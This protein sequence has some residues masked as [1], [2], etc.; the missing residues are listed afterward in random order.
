MFRLTFNA[1]G[2]VLRSSNLQQYMLSQEP[3]LADIIIDEYEEHK[4]RFL[5]LAGDEIRRRWIA[6]ATQRLHSTLAAYV[7]GISQPVIRGDTVA[8]TIDNYESIDDSGK[9]PLMIEEG[10]G[11][12]RLNDAIT[13]NKV[14]NFTHTDPRSR[15]SVPGGSALGDPYRGHWR[16]NSKQKLGDLQDKLVSNVRKLRAGQRLKAGVAPKLRARARPGPRVGGVKTRLVAHST[17]IYA[18]L[19][20][21]A[22]GA[23][24]GP[25]NRLEGSTFRTMVPASEEP[26]KWIHPG[27]TAYRIGDEVEREMDQVIATVIR[28]G[29]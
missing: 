23:K 22:A 18:G 24:R 25:R 9:V 16:Y 11:P 13:Q 5:E 10:K 12:Y 4:Q 26:G 8:V 2:Q 15:Q 7:Q 14:V 17:D 6:K 27:V 29:K 20:K 19:T 28:I 3:D 1:A 21:T